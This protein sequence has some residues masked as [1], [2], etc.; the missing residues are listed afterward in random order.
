MRSISKFGETF[1]CG[2]GGEWV[3]VPVVNDRASNAAIGELGDIARALLDRQKEDNKP[4]CKEGRSIL[5]S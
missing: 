2:P 5:R 4:A 1:C 3:P